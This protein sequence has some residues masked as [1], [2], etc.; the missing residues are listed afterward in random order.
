[1]KHK[2]RILEMES[3]FNG[4]LD[5]AMKF[6]K[7]DAMA[8]IIIVL[9]NL[10]GG[11]GVGM[12]G[13]GMAAGDALEKYAILTIGDGLVS[14]LPAFFSAIAAG[15]LVTRTTDDE[16]ESDLAPTIAV[17]IAGKP[18]VLLIPGFPTLVFFAIAA[19][20][21]GFG[22]WKHPATSAQVRQKLGMP[23]EVQTTPVGQA[24]LAAPELVS[25]E[26]LQLR[27]G[28]AAN[29]PEYQQLTDY[30]TQTIAALS[31]R[32]GVPL[33][34]MHLLTDP[35][36]AANGWA[37]SA[38]DAPL[39]EGV[40]EAEDVPRHIA[41]IVDHLL[42]RNLSVFLGL[43]EVTE[44]LN[45]LGETAPEV[46]KEAVR[47]VPTGKIAEVLR[48]LADEAVPLRNLKDIMEALSDVGQYE[49]D[50]A[51]MVER[52]RVM[53]RRHLVA[54][55]CVEGRM[56]AIMIG[57]EVEGAIRS[58]LTDVD[59]QMRLAI[60]PMQMRAM[61][62]LL[63]D[64]C[65]QTESRIILTSQDLRRPLRLMIAADLPDVAVIAFNELN[66]AVPLDIVGELNR[67]PDILAHDNQM[68]YAE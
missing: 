32:S 48:L 24:R 4:S 17:Q 62:S 31:V 39:G 10:L 65:R 42:S 16:N 27:V 1:M 49:R 61:I 67:A 3:K 58:T 66:P 45:R 6:V 34:S 59:G 50:A 12:F 47:A 13:K 18:H 37:L 55:L 41:L 68:E 5:G 33:P 11:L 14:Q 38:H 20:F 22:L 57:S 29:G 15:L 23:A 52:I 40:S 51:P 36:L 64:Q 26:P 60:N 46:V 2:R 9:I 43:Q 63:D 44:M 19:V 54:P 8:A 7:G 56:R 35:G 25:V 28:M 53:T 30:V 21:I